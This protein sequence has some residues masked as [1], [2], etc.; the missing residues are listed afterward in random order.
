MA[1]L[2]QRAPKSVVTDVFEDLRPLV[3]SVALR[4]ARKYSRDVAETRAEAYLHFLEAYH[5]YDP[6]LNGPLARRVRYIVGLR[7]L[8]TV[9]T[10]AERAE[11][12]QRADVDVARIAVVPGE[13]FDRDEFDQGI[14]DDARAVFALLWDTPADLAD[15]IRTTPPS[16]DDSGAPVRRCLARYCKRAFGWTAARV[17]GAFEELRDAAGA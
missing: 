12:L 6:E 1:T 15:A 2:M 16:A 17:R 9:R 10:E 13:P 4:F 7:L 5:A 14:G 11:L 3:D 8:D